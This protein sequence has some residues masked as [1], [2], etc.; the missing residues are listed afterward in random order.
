M[1][2]PTLTF[3]DNFQ[4]KMLVDSIKINYLSCN[5]IKSQ[6]K[7]KKKGKPLKIYIF[8]PS[9]LKKEEVYMGHTQNEKNIYTEIHLSV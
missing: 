1:I 6:K 2:M 9:L 4:W 5:P 3:L 8:G 7:K